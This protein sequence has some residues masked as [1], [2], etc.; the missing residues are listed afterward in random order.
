MLDLINEMMRAVKSKAYYPALIT[1]VTIPDICSFLSTGSTT[2]NKARYV[3]WFND[4]VSYRFDGLIDGNIAY[5]LRCSVLHEGTLEVKSKSFTQFIVVTSKNDIS[6]NHW[7]I[8]RGSSEYLF[9]ELNIFCHHIYESVIAWI[10]KVENTKSYQD[11]YKKFFK[12][13]KLH[14]PWA[15]ALDVIAVF[16]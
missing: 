4:F 10:N 8:K 9:I 16:Q 13:E 3:K 2:G 7:G 12:K 15:E 11:N 6:V 5:D 14:M 1:A